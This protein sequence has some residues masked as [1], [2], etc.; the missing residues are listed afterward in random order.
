MAE[1][2]VAMLAR[3]RAD[4]E[5]AV[6]FGVLTFTQPARH[7]QHIGLE[8]FRMFLKAEQPLAKLLIQGKT[9]FVVLKGIQGGSSR[10]GPTDRHREASMHRGV[11]GLM[12]G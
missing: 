9:I 12:G 5:Q 4:L 3:D 6:G 7:H 8:H 11:H 10:E 2:V 1:Q